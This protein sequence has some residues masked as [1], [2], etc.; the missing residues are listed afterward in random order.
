MRDGAGTSMPAMPQLSP[1]VQVRGAHELLRVA[2]S[3]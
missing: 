1:N 3:P 2:F